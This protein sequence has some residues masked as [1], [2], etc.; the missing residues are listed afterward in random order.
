MFVEPGSLEAI[1]KIGEAGKDAGEKLFECEG[2]RWPESVERGR[3]GGVGG[4][5]ANTN[6]REIFRG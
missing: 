5:D 1:V 6:D 3:W 4:V 2:G